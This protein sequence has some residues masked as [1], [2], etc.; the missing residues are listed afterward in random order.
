[1]YSLISHVKA[2]DSAAN[3]KEAVA[4]EKVRQK[5]SVESRDICLVGFYIAG[6]LLP[7]LSHYE[8]GVVAAELDKLLTSI[9]YRLSLSYKLTPPLQAS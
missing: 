9:S 2:E 5:L 4:M 6:H 8:D 3:C 7:S 1:M